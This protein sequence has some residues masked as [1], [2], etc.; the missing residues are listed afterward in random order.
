MEGLIGE[1]HP[2]RQMVQ[3]IQVVAPSDATVLLTGETGTG[4]E[5]VA[6]AIHDRSPRRSKPFVPVNCGALPSH[7]LENELFGH[8]KGA[9]TDATAPEKGL[10]AE[11]EMGTLFLDEV[12]ALSASTQ[13][14][15]LRFLQN[16]EYRPL[17][18]S[19][20]TISDVRIIAATNAD[21][22][23]QVQASRFREDL[24]YRL[25]VLSLN[26]P[27]LRERTEDIPLL[28]THFL[29]QYESHDG[30]TPL[31]L[32]ADTL[33]KLMAYSWPGNVREL[34]AVIQRAAIMSVSPVLQ[35]EDIDLPGS[36]Q[37]S[38]SALDDFHAAKARAIEQFER[39]Y[40]THLLAAHEDNITRAAK[41]A[42]TTRRSMQRLMKKYDLQR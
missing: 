31:R 20:S 27:S 7:L 25:N 39:A 40:L 18:C 12:D 26:L 14:K 13:V 41:H 30:C 29:R 34:E 24:Y 10:V 32:A 15:L 36:H 42:G 16:H 3:K 6:Q 19:R 8:A 22:R 33:P 17:G 4:K 11:A 28:A 1:S 5:L 9:F 21:L 37:S 38:T 2:F 23:Q 35:P